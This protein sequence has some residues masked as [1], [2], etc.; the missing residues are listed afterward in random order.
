MLQLVYVSSANP[1][2]PCPTRDILTVSRRNNAR[3]RITGLLYADGGRF[4]QALEGPDEAVAAAYARI[5]QDPRH[6]AIVILLQRQVERREFGH[7]EM[8]RRAPGADAAGFLADVE[9]LTADA[10]PDVRG[11]FAGLVQA[12]ALA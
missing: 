6:R 4:L 7:W 9:R 5:R 11:T 12:R 10:A 8:A 2:V 3:D 1:A